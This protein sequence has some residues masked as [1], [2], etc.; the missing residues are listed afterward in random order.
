MQ[1]VCVRV[2]VRVCANMCMARCKAS[3]LIPT[4]M[5]A[6]LKFLISCP[7]SNTHKP[8]NLSSK[9][10]FDEKHRHMYTNVR[11]NVASSH[12]NETF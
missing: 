2:C 7:T 10:K 4:N 8:I 12:R 3:I 11:E 1:C 5:S 9:L 6:G